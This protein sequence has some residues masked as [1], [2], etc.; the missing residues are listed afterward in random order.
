MGHRPP[1]QRSDCLFVTTI[2][3]EFFIYTSKVRYHSV[4]CGVKFYHLAV[5]ENV[6]CRS[7]GGIR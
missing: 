4:L 6:L 7:F 5:A 2:A 3:A 1:R